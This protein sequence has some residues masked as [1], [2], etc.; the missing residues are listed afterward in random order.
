MAFVD[1]QAVGQQ[2]HGVVACEDL[3]FEQRFVGARRGGVD[4]DFQRVD[5]VLQLPD[6]LGLAVREKVGV[7][8]PLGESLHRDHLL[9]QV[10]GVVAQGALGEPLAVA[11]LFVGFAVEKVHQQVFLVVREADVSRI[12]D[13]GVHVAVGGAVVVDQHVV[14][15]VR[16][17]L[18]PAD[19]D[20][21]VFDAVE[22][23]PVLE[24]EGLFLLADV[25][26]RA[27]QLLVGVRDEVVADE[28]AADGDERHQYDER[29]GD[30]DQRHAGRL[31]GQQFVVLAQVA[32]GHDRRQQHR[33]RQAHRDHVGHEIGHQLDDDSGAE[34]LAHQF[35]DVAPYDVHHQHEHDDEKREDH[36]AQVG[37]QNE[38]MD[39]LHAAARCFLLRKDTSFTSISVRVSVNIMAAPGGTSKL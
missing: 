3:L 24:F 25:V 34:A 36:R 20:R 5:V 32:H 11:R 39:G 37:F 1:L 7:G 18:L 28:E 9:L 2:Q 15:Q 14:E 33:Q 21:H 16:V 27:V 22:E 8:A 10:E 35:V 29:F 30:L 38:F 23:E 31:H 17:G 13:D 6:I 4:L 12:G 26:E 19:A